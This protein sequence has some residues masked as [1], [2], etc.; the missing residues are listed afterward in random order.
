MKT[1]VGRVQITLNPN[2]QFPVDVENPI[3]PFS[4]R[5]SVLLS[6]GQHSATLSS[7]PTIPK[8]SPATIISHNLSRLL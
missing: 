6:S 3:S 4:S 2:A 5:R 1:G 7:Y 8:A